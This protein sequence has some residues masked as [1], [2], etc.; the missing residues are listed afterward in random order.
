MSRVVFLMD[1]IEISVYPGK[2]SSINFWTA[3]P[4]SNYGNQKYWKLE[5]AL[6]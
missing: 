6:N 5:R 2:R 1:K 3:L 4:F